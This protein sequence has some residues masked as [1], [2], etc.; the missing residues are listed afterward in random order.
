MTEYNLIEQNKQNDMAAG[1]ID[2]HMKNEVGYLSH[3]MGKN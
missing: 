3:F 1:T 2:I